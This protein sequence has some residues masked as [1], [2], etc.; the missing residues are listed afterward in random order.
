MSPAEENDFH[1]AMA[2]QES[3]DSLP[4]NFNLENFEQNTTDDYS[5]NI[6]GPADDLVTENTKRTSLEVLA[7]AAL[8]LELN[9]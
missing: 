3:L 9:E 4:N 8:Q 7:H 2:M 6:K 1:L 5:H